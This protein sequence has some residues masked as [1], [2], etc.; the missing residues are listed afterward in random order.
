MPA[1]CSQVEIVNCSEAPELH[2]IEVA[3]NSSNL[4][5]LIPLERMRIFSK[6]VSSEM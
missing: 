2:L 1:Q 5:S 3:V 6:P 4:N